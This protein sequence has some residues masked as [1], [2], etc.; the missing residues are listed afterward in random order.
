MLGEEAFEIDHY[1][2]SA[3]ALAAISFRYDELCVP[4]IVHNFLFTPPALD[5]N[6]LLLVKTSFVPCSGGKPQRKVS[7]F[8]SSTPVTFTVRHLDAAAAHIIG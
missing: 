2:T 7:G 3:A 1:C 6:T 4:C 8:H 5:Y